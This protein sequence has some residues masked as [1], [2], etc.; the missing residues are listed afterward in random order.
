M[1]IRVA[2]VEGD[3]CMDIIGIMLSFLGQS[4]LSWHNSCRSLNHPFAQLS[5]YSTISAAYLIL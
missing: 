5:V 1:R 3:F 4:G 2:N